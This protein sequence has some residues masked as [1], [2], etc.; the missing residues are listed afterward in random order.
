VLSGASGGAG[1]MIAT[2][3]MV[4]LG[5]T[6]AQAIA[7]AKFSGFGVSAG[8]SSRFFKEKLTDKKTVIIFSI[9]GAIA[10]LAGSLT[11]VHFRDQSDIIQRIMGIAIL[12]IGVPMLYIRNLGQITKHPPTWLKA[13][14]FFCWR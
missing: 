12:A 9:I 11:L 6:P 1:G 2:P 8:A 7:T 13:V 5:L 10:A 3:F 4:L 14:G